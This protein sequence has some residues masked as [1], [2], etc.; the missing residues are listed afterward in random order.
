MGTDRTESHRRGQSASKTTTKHPYAAIE[1]RVIDSPAYVALTFSARSLL[2]E[3]AR[4][5]TKDNN[6]HL[7]AAFSY[8]GRHGF[9]ENTLSRAIAELIKHGMIYRTRSGGYQQGA[10]QYAVTWLPVRNKQGLFLDGFK[11]CAWRDWQ[12]EATPRKKTPPPK[13]MDTHRKNGEWTMPT[14]PIFEAGYPPKNEDNEL[15]PCTAVKTAHPTRKNRPRKPLTSPF[16]IRL[17]LV[18]DR[19]RL[20]NRLP[21][22]NTHESLPL[23]AT[24]PENSPDACAT[25][26]GNSSVTK[27]PVTNDATS[28][29]DD[30]AVDGSEWSRFS[31]DENEGVWDEV[32]GEFIK[33][34]PKRTGHTRKWAE[35]TFNNLRSKKAA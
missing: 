7:Q 8:M 22:S 3:L 5:L 20:L 12:P 32:R 34:P 31:D 35:E 17:Q 18:A 2:L 1:H 25:D 33:L 27:A 11:P 4:Q 21:N 24:E 29:P 30:S 13:L 26:T 19:G 6:G 15:M 9:S 23:P 28:Q 16:A 10:A 14:P